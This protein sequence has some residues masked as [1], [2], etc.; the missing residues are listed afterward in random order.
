M[1]INDILALS[2]SLSLSLSI[3]MSLQINEFHGHCNSDSVG[4]E[5]F[6]VFLE[7]L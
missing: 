1:N 2:L 6:F 5:T 3:Y 4:W 7:S